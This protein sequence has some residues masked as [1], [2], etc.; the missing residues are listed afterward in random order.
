MTEIRTWADGF[1]VWHARVPVTDSRYRD[2]LTAQA[3]IADELAQ[4]EGP[5]FDRAMVLVERVSGGETTVVYREVTDV[6]VPAPR[7]EPHWTTDQACAHV[8]KVRD[9]TEE[10]ARRWLGR[11][12]TAVSRERG[13]EGQN[14]YVPAVVRDRARPDT[15]LPGE[16]SVA[17]LYHD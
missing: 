7:H 8:A 1:G 11:H 4:R 16:T 2:A 10:S 9:I 13:R 5:Q 15:T 12:V 17:G 3:A 6:E 14:L